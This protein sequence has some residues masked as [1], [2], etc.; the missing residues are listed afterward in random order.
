MPNSSLRQLD[1]LVEALG[2]APGDVEPF[3]WL[4]GKFAL[5]LVARL[6]HRP[7]GRYV[8]VT[9]ITP[10]QFGEGKTVVAIGLAMGLT[11]LG[12]R[13]VCTLREPSLAPVFG[14]KGGGAGGGLATLAPADR[15]DLHFTGDFHAVAAANNLLAAMVDNHVARGLQPSC[16][17]AEVSWKRC[18]DV[19]DKGL[20][21]IVSGLGR[22]PQA[23]VRETGFD[24]TAASETMAILSL[25]R[26][27]PD[28]RERLGRIVVALPAKSAP[29][30]ATC[31]RAA[32]AMAVLLRDAV[33]PNLVQTCEGSPAIVHT[34]PFANTA[35]GNSSIVAD[36]IALRLADYVVTESGFGADCGAEKFF[37]IKCR[38]GNLRPAAEVLV[39]TVRA[40]KVHSGRYAIAPA[41]PLPPALFDENLPAIRE[42]AANLRAHIDILKS[43]GVP[44][45]AAINRF[46][47]DTAAELALAKGLATDFGADETALVEAFSGGSAGTVELAEAVVRAAA[48]ESDWR[49][50]YPLEAS[51]EDK[52]RRIAHQVYG[53]ADVELSPAAARGLARFAAEGFGH[54]P[55]C[56]AKTQY[57]LSH[58]PQRLGRPRGFVFPIREARL[59]AGAGFIHA[60]AGDMATMP[61]LP[62]RPS[63]IDLDLD[64]DGGILGLH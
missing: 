6:Q 27:L 61:G 48:K 44:V 45:V 36:R 50:T 57:S 22:S 43:F 59:C 24:L 18:M 60:I 5:D 23:A 58:D 37:N 20:A 7:M 9:A 62:A 32:G 10:T 12:Q 52:L 40:L 53:A 14:I 1:E 55:I 63:A 39:C 54:L 8:G 42:G 46:A 16:S 35:D 17:P 49:P 31:V 3:G 13:A 15:I 56:V 64:A 11:R 47:T 38:I 28:L 21:S 19:G 41:R 26:D 2:L 25:A 30:T 29:L 34:G 4:Q 51:L 33:R